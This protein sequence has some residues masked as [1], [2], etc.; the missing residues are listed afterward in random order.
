VSK[1]QT[2]ARLFAT[3]LI[4]ALSI[5]ACV[6][7]TEGPQAP[8][9]LAPGAPGASI[10][11]GA[12]AAG[13][14]GGGVGGGIGGG[15]ATGP[16]GPCSAR[17]PPRL[18]L[19][20]DYQQLN[21]LKALL[22]ADAI[23]ATDAA[24]HTPQTKPFTQK[25]VVVNASLVHQRLA[26]SAT[27]SES[28]GTRFAQLTGCDVAR[29]DD[30][31]ARRYLAGFAARA[32]RRPVA[33]AEVDDVIAVY[34]VGKAT[35]FANGVKRAVEA[36]LAAPSFMYRR[37]LGAADPAGGL[38]LLPHEL[39]SE[40][41]FL[42]T[43]QP[44]DAELS[45][46]ADSG[47]LAQPAELARQV[48]R[49]LAKREAQDALSSTLISS[50]G[51]SNLFGT[52]KDPQLFPEYGPQLQGSMFRETELFVRDVLWDRAAPLRELLSSRR[53]FVNAP[54]AALYG[55]PFTGRTDEFVAVTLPEQRAGLLTQPAVMATLART[56]TTSVVA[57]GLF[58]RGAMLCLPKLPGPPESLST[59]IQE[60]LDA[61][62]TER[63]RAEVRKQ[64]SMCSSCHAGI[65][66][67]GLLLEQYDPLGRYRTTL[68]GETIDASA[69]VAGGSLAGR[70]ANAIAFLEAAAAAPEFSACVGTRLLAYATQDEELKA[71]DCQ[72]TEV[73]EAAG[74]GELTMKQLVKAVTASPALRVRNQE[75]P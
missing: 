39:A 5:S 11:G 37:E 31:C 46:A 48:E 74:S 38:S 23:D 61:D 67:F 24:E 75:A 47:A 54:L 15:G 27:A 18:V 4:C 65:D 50:W 3:P 41:S 58:V 28:F 8:G 32:F 70:Y 10:G 63:E 25:G 35:S 21:S 30:A 19:L 26:W 73:I 6:G 52:E 22:G 44:P 72:V 62:M 20:S 43:D 9:S 45:G 29:A 57:R 12:G 2:T 40:V 69:D 13:A 36:I 55:I 66:P 17:L 53:S 59:Q 34:T 14:A 42:L 49:L 7:A 64:N 51:L 16:Q 71:T 33:A 68:E 60:L 56:D 1:V